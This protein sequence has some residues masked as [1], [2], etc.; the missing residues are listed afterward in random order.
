M[1]RCVYY[2]TAC[3]G[4]IRNLCK[5]SIH[6]SKGMRPLGKPTTKWEGTINMDLEE[7]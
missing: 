4:E 3:M 2:S 7:N 1:C 5:R 6:I